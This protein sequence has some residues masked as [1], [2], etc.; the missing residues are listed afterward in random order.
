MKRKGV[1]QTSKTQRKFQRTSLSLAQQNEIKSL[2]AASIRQYS[3]QTTELKSYD[4]TV[5]STVVDNVTGQML[6]LTGMA[7]GVAADGRIGNEVYVKGVLLRFQLIPNAAFNS[8]RCIVFR[9]NDKATPTA[10]LILQSTSTSTGFL[11]ALLRDSSQSFQVLYDEIIVVG[12]DQ[13]N[14]I[15][16]RKVYLPKKGSGL[17]QAVWNDAGNIVK[18][19]IYAFFFSDSAAID[20]PGLK[21]QGRVHFTDK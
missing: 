16:T 8:V 14:S 3:R 21:L 4:R 10:A 17:G 18:G 13:M 15:E 9:W 1:Y 6:T 20:A 11:S 2:A 7:Q 12:T 5:V 19:H